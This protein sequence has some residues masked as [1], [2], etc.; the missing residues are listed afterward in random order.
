MEEYRSL[1]GQL[2][3]EVKEA[4]DLERYALIGIG[5]I[6]SWLASLENPTPMVTP[7]WLFPPL[8]AIMGWVRARSIMRHIDQ[9]AGYVRK[10][11]A[12]VYGAGGEIIGWETTVAQSK[13]AHSSPGLAASQRLFWQVVIVFSLLGSTYG[14]LCQ[15]FHFGH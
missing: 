9:V 4:R 6:F 2:D 11:E 8:L 1:R 14:F 7:A 3:D 15:L 12:H 5:L 13:K 10:I